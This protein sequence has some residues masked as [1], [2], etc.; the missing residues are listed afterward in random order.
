[1]LK[2][3]IKLNGEPIIYNKEVEFELFNLNYNFL[4]NLFYNKII[5][6]ISLEGNII[7]DDNK[8]KI[9]II[10]LLYTNEYVID[11]QIIFLNNIYNGL[12]LDSN[13]NLVKNINDKFILHP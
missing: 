10:L 12:Y 11:L 8:F 9:Y 7:Y 6:I 3:Y 1:M 5:K 4:L 2:K 13:I